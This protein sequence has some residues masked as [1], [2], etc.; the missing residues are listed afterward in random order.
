MSEVVD[1][2]LLELKNTNTCTGLA[3]IEKDVAAEDSL[4]SFAPVHSGQKT[5]EERL[6]Q[7]SIG[8][9]KAVLSN[10]QSQV[11]E[12]GTLDAA[13]TSGDHS[14]GRD[15]DNNADLEWSVVQGVHNGVANLERN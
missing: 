10:V 4:A 15:G 8:R 13:I 1:R 2:L 7:A 5:V 14:D 6:T 9:R 3:S 11:E 12:L